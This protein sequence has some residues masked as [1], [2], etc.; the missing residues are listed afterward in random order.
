MKFGINP[1]KILEDKEYPM[2]ID[3]W[4]CGVKYQNSIK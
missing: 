1:S 3:W 2:V 4:R